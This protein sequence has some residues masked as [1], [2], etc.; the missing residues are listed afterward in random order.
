MDDT[1]FLVNQNSTSSSQVQFYLQKERKNYAV[2]GDKSQISKILKT[3][4]NQGKFNIVICGGDG[5]IN[6]FLNC[7]MGLEEKVR[8]KIKIG[9]IPTGRANDFA[10][11]LNIPLAI[12]QASYILDNDKI[13]KVD[14]IQV[15]AKF[16]VTGGGFGLPSQV[17][18][19][20]NKKTIV[21]NIMF[22]DL[23]YYLYVL[24]RISIGYKGVHIKS[25]DNKSI[26]TN[27]MMLSINNQDFMGKRFLL[28][29]KSI[30]N[31]GFFELCAIPKPR[32]M[33]QDFAMV[34][35]VMKGTHVMEKKVVYKKCKKA[36]VLL[37]DKCW[38]MG[39]GELLEYNDK[40]EFGII[41]NALS[42]K[43]FPL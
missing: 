35:K 26:N 37:Y 18:Q 41:H 38:F 11:K 30:I 43:F 6:S 21:L 25:I 5:S 9:I 3:Q 15:N 23:I 17:V 24:R 32:N 1:L 36:S 20:L 33:L 13:K 7:Y 31:D 39:D 22:K 42:V 34:H 16:F 10:R 29:P 19:D 4:I 28:S 14:V 27:C 12:R 8:Q 2:T 40:F